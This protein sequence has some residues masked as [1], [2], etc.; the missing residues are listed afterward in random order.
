MSDRINLIKDTVFKKFWCAV[1]D[2][3]F[4]IWMSRLIMI[5][6]HLETMWK[7]IFCSVTVENARRVEGIGH[8]AYL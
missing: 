1:Q 3:D 7:N 4:I 8:S 5:S 6:V 2:M